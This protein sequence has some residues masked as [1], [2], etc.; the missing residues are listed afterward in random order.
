LVPLYSA[1]GYINKTESV[2]RWFTKRIKCLSRLPYDNRLSVLNNDRLELRRLR[3]DLL[4]C[5][6]IVYNIVDLPFNDFFT[7]NNSS[8]TRGNSLK[9]NL[10]ISRI[11]ARSNFFAVRIIP[12]WNKLS[13]DVVNSPN[14]SIFATK[15]N[16]LD[17]SP[18][19]IGKS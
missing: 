11:N 19:I 16:S 4:M 13:D 5:F 8:I 9:L 1:I 18:F 12:V 15:I 10:P 7:F 3:A 6:K 2:Q 14:I 17:L